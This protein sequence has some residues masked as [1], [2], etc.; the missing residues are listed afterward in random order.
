MGWGQIWAILVE[1]YRIKLHAQ[2][3]KPRPYG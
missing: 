2:F 3:G 1:D